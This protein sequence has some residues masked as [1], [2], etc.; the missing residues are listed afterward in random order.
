[1]TEEC[2]ILV[3][4]KLYP[5]FQ[6]DVLAA[7]TAFQFAFELVV[8]VCFHCHGVG[9]F[10]TVLHTRHLE[11]VVGQITGSYR[12]V[13][14]NLRIVF[15]GQDAVG[16]LGRTEQTRD[17]HVFHT[18]MDFREVL[19]VHVVDVAHRYGTKVVRLVGHVVQEPLV[20]DGTLVF[21]LDHLCIQ[22]LL[23]G[24][25]VILFI[26]EIVHQRHPI[27]FRIARRLIQ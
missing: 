19:H 13:E 2:S 23:D 15:D 27:L 4:R 12:F 17:V 10:R 20:T 8:A 3:D 6:R 5:C 16:R 21:R 1:M 14:G 26:T 25:L 9:R 18:A 24:F 22:A 7:E 11:V